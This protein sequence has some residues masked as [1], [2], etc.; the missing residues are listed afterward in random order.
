MCFG[1][2]GNTTPPP[3]QKPT[4]FQYMPNTQTDV[5]RQAAT[6][7]AKGYTNTANYGSD[8]AAG[9]VPAPTPATTGGM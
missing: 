5:Q 1:S 8:L 9:S 6:M 7:E 3:P 2:K 4:T